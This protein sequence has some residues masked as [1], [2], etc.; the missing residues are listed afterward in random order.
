[1]LMRVSVGIH[2]E[3]IDAAIE[4]YNL[5]SERYFTHASPTLFSSGTPRPQLSRY[6]SCHLSTSALREKQDWFTEVPPLLSRSQ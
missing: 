3:D 6:T 4:T 1:M 5:L 2:G